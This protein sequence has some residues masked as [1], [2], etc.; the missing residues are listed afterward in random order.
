[1]KTNNNKKKNDSKFHLDKKQY[2][3]GHFVCW[4]LPAGCE[5]R[6]RKTVFFPSSL[7]FMTS[8]Y[9]LLYTK[10][11]YMKGCLSKFQHLV[12]WKEKANKDT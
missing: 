2:I 5:D 10:A 12:K 9:H 11:L 8:L 4:I 6:A 7:F 1:M 3:S